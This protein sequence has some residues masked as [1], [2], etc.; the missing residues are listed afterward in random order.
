MRG[1]V[2]PRRSDAEQRLGRGGGRRAN[3][4]SFELEFSANGGSSC[5]APQ[6]RPRSGCEDSSQ[7]EGIFGEGRTVIACSGRSR[8]GGCASP[9]SPR[10]MLWTGPSQLIRCRNR[11]WH[12]GARER[13][14]LVRAARAMTDSSVKLACKTGSPRCEHRGRGKAAA[15]RCCHAVYSWLAPGERL[16]EGRPLRRALEA[17]R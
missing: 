9:A 7:P 15:S 16:G 6:N 11:E 1:R 10:L 12:E 17:Y 3:N 5:P 8:R 13:P 4:G 14:C 2:A